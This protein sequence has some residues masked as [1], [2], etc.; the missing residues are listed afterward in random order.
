MFTLN[1]FPLGWHSSSS[2]SSCLVPRHLNINTEKLW[3]FKEHKETESVK[4]PNVNPPGPPPGVGSTIP[5]PFQSRIFN[6]P[7]ESRIYFR[8]SAKQLDPLVCWYLPTVL[9][10]AK[11]F[12]GIYSNPGSR[13]K[14][15]L[16]LLHCKEHK[17]MKSV[18]DPNLDPPDRRH[19]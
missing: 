13:I 7:G 4:D 16:D 11:W 3:L 6:K 18:R 15:I 12:T 8:W 9:A 17:E 1:I 14:F 5:H 2:S 10:E 19:V